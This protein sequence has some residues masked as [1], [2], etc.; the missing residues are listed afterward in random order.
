MNTAQTELSYAAS[1]YDSTNI[2]SQPPHRWRED[3]NRT[4][5]RRTQLTWGYYAGLNPWQLVDGQLRGQE[6]TWLE[7]TGDADIYCNHQRWRF[8]NFNKILT[9]VPF[10]KYISLL[11]LPWLFAV[12]SL[13]EFLPKVE[14]AYFVMAFAGLPLCALSAW[15]YWGR[16]LKAYLY[17]MSLP[18]ALAAIGGAYNYLASGDYAS[19]VMCGYIVLAVFMGVVGF[20][21]LLDLYLRL[22]KHDGSELNRQTGM[23]TIAR[24]FRQ[25]FVAPFYEFDVTME[26]RPDH[27][28]AVAWRSGCT[29]GTP[30]LRCF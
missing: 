29:T 18:V 24:R 5:L 9:L 17:L 7:R 22:F 15:L 10:F 4:G 16:G 14:L 1:A 21:F 6:Q 8:E 13:L 26:Y 30:L 3:E 12:V 2:P 28:A 27:L 19:L 11:L 25:P 23:V 20:D